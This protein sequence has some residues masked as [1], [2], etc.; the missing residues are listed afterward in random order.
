VPEGVMM[1]RAPLL[2]DQGRSDREADDEVA[3]GRAV[4]LPSALAAPVLRL[5][6]DELKE[7]VVDPSVLRDSEPL[8]A[9]LMERCDVLGAVRGG[10]TERE[11]LDPPL[12]ADAPLPGEA[13][14]GGEEKDP[15]AC[16][17]G[18]EKVRGEP[19]ELDGDRVAGG[20]KD[21]DGADDLGGAEKDCEGAENERVGAEDRGAENDWEGG[22]E[23][24]RS[25]GAAERD[26]AEKERDG[27][28]D[29]EGA[30]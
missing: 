3:A 23:N 11:P 18:V 9:G 1:R 26:G 6:S 12:P 15:W 7:P 4:E 21:R 29:R 2:E 5:A 16:P 10:S 13:L 28:A 8:A 22:A 20:E 17:D 19:N 25:D 30:E 14:R 27:A 24:D